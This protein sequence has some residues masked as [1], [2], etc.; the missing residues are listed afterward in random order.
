[1]LFKARPPTFRPGRNAQPPPSLRPLLG[2]AALAPAAAVLLADVD[3]R[4]RRLLI[5]GVVDE[6]L[7]DVGGEAVEGL[8]DVDVAL[9]GDLEEG[10]AE[11]VGEGLALLGADDALVLPVALV[12]DEDLVDALGGV[13]FYVGEPGA[14]VCVCQPATL[15][16]SSAPLG[17][18]EERDVLSND[19][20]SVTSYTSRMPMAPR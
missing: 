12:S 5:L 6:A 1:M 14:D 4:A 7:L 15:P 3:A 17:G 8:V 10:D 11:L 2:L 9:G 18:P 19:L 16:A 20:W 13:L